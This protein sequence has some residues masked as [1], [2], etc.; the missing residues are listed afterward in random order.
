MA[1][2]EWR[3]EWEK[4]L[5]AAK[6]EGTVAVLGPRQVQARDLLVGF[7]KVYGIKVEYLGGSGRTMSPRVLSERRAQRYGWDVYVGGTTTGLTALG[8]AGALDPLAPAMIL[9]TV[10][11]PKYWRDGHHEYADRAGKLQLG[12]AVTR[13]S[14]IMINPKL[15]KPEEIRSHR[16]LLDPKWTGKIV[17]DD[18]RRSGPGQA[19]FLF[20]LLHPDL[21]ADFI[22]AL[23]KQK[24]VLLA[25]YQQELDGLAHGRYPILLGSSDA[26]A[27]YKISQGVPI[28]LVDPR[29]LKE[30][31]D[32]GT[33]NGA[34]ALMNRAPHPNAARVFINWLLSKEA[35]TGYSKN[36]Q[37]VSRRLDVP[38]DHMR[39][40]RVPPPG[41]IGTYS[42]DA[43]DKKDALL[44]L[45][46]EV[47]GR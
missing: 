33:S 12:F 3:Q 39:E 43:L 13:R 7:E 6:K 16:D 20:F 18:P 14:T 15:V 35:Q 21:G 44:A 40:W 19:T 28:H 42:E 8:P 10:K 22:R 27:E 5:A 29:Q 26:S 46:R 38:T 47:F 9:P 30:G 32:A 31:T 34:T 45:L 37:Y 2:D 17:M 23:A 24:A 41:T 25:D 1:Q 11:D 36:M 4:V